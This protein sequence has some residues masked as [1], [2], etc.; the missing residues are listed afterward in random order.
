[1]K[2]LL[3]TL[4]MGMVFLCP[5]KSQ[6]KITGNILDEENNP[7]SFANVILNQM[8]DS[9]MVKVESTDENGDFI[10]QGISSGTYQIQISY[11]GLKEFLSEPISI[12][13]ENI[14]M[15]I[16]RMENLSNELAEVTVT[17]TRPVLE[18]KP[19]KLVFNVEGSVNASGN[20][21]LELLRKAPGVMID[22]NDNISLSGKNGVTIYLNGKPSFLSGEDLAAYLKSIRSEDIDKIE[23][24]KNP[25]SK[26]DA[27]GNAGIINVVMKKDKK[28]GGNGRINLGYNQGQRSSINGGM[29]GNYKNKKIN[30]FTRLS[31]GEYNGFNQFDLYRIQEG[32]IFDQKSFREFKNDYLSYKLGMDVFLNDKNTLGILWDGGYNV[33]ANSAMSKTYIAENETPEDLNSVLVAETGSETTSNRMNLNVNFQSKLNENKNLNVDADFGKYKS[34]TFDDQPN[35]YMDANEMNILSEN[36]LKNYSDTDISIGTFK[37]DYDQKVW[38]GELGV[39]LKTSVVLTDNLF[40]VFNVVDQVDVFNDD[41]SRA[42][43][44]LE[45]VNAVYLTYGKQWDK[46][47][48]QLG[49]R[50]EQTYSEGK[51]ESQVE[52]ENDKVTRSYVDF[53]PS[54]GLTYNMNENN[55]FQ[56][57][58]SRRLQR[59]DYENLNPFESMLDELT[60]ERGNPFLNPEYSNSVSLNHTFKQ[61]FNTS[62]TYSHTKDMMAEIIVAEENKIFNSWL[63]LAQQN[64]FNLTVSAPMPITKWWDTYTNVSSAYDMNSTYIPE[65]NKTEKLNIYV[66]NAYV[67][68]NF[69]LPKGFKMELSGWY[70]SPFLFGGFVRMNQ[71]YSVNV[72]MQKSFME[73]KAKIK[74]SLDDIFFSEKW[75]GENNY[76]NDFARATGYNDS[77]RV[78]LN[79]TYSF[80]NQN[81]KSRRRSSGSEEE[82]QRLGQ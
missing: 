27:E 16:I 52:V 62:F 8:S 26:Y 53:F 67:Q 51:L 9:M 28:L 68:N 6:N 1:M 49:A 32:M 37:I 45:N 36:I 48:V 55:Q 63:N 39:G 25:S 73:G 44:Y 71:M 69:N 66:F 5:L 43:Q 17:A 34:S 14:E 50:V 2:N 13:G 42:F 33:S 57:N 24:I 59:P 38:G 29:S 60:F 54:M 23:I 72:G 3:L 61:R 15:G 31:G 78:K 7:V 80:G 11:V 22:N 18:I 12:Q 4:V 82:S 21:A 19:N 64:S 46:I 41:R 10:L 30:V 56:L 74:V 35:Y 58:Y 76:G 77:R 70:T 79:F 40:E 65:L 81:V 20:S 47:G 75:N